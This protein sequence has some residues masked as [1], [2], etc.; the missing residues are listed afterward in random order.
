MLL[1]SPDT[2]WDYLPTDRGGG[3]RGVCLGRQSYGSP[4][5]S[6]LG[7]CLHGPPRTQE[8]QR[9]LGAATRRF[10]VLRAFWGAGWVLKR[11]PPTTNVGR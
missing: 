1:H 3:A 5:R 9:A 7:S 8:L 11:P 2:P 6:C 10:T 4:H